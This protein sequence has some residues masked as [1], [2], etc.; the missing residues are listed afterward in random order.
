MPQKAVLTASISLS[1]RRLFKTVCP[2]LDPFHTNIHSTL[3]K[4]LYML[5]I[6]QA[7]CESIYLL[8]QKFVQQ[9]TEMALGCNLKQL[10]P[11]ANH[12]INAN[13]ET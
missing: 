8:L 12:R 7:F 9:F 4:I 3:L 11:I 10:T 2:A 1:M 5:S 13:Y 6:E